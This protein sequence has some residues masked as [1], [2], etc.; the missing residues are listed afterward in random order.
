MNTSNLILQPTDTAQ[1]H[2]LISEVE[3]RQALKLGEELESYL[4]FLMMRFMGK[5]EMAASVLGLD[6]LDGIN[7]RGQQRQELLQELGDKC[8]LFAGLFPGRA[9]T[10]HV[11]I[12]YFVY[13]GQSAYAT[14]AK[15]ASP[16]MAVLYNDLVKHFVMLMDLLNMLR[17]SN[18][19][20]QM[21][22]LEAQE[23]WADTGSK[24]SLRNTP[25]A[26]P[27]YIVAARS[28]KR[29]MLA[30]I[31]STIIFILLSSRLL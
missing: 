2:S 13:L 28:S 30:M 21:Q 29:N 26:N 15:R 20:A 23:L 24:Q 19:S 17:D 4:V 18:N 11:R 10:R 22:L 5:P 31:S 27:R 3:Q 8:L 9:E 6:F 25:S 16:Q 14:V 12:S 7:A 1:W